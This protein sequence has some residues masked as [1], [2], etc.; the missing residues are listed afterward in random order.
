MHNRVDYCDAFRDRFLAATRYIHDN[1]GVEAFHNLSPSNPDRVVPAFSATIFDS[2][3]IAVDLGIRRN[4]ARDCSEGLSARRRKALQDKGLQNN[5]SFETM[6]TE[7]IR[8]R[9]GQMYRELFK[10]A[11][12]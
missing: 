5:L 7:T 3:M 10:G 12:Q 2:V 11:S 4:I 1:L 8:N 6:R 9:V